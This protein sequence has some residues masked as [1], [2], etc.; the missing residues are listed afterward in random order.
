[1]SESARGRQ[2]F[3]L[4]RDYE[5]LLVDQLWSRWNAVPLDLANRE[6]G[7]VCA[8]LLARQ[9]RLGIEFA[10][11]PSIWNG[12]SAPVLC[13][14][15]VDLLINL[16]W[17]LKDP[18][19]RSRKF[20]LYGLGQA[21]LHLEHR[22]A[23]LHAEGHDP[24]EDPVIQSFEAWID[25][26]RFTFLTEVDVGS[27]SG[28]SVRE[29]ATEAGCLGLLNYSYVPFSAATHSMWHHIGRFNVI[30]C[31]SPLHRHHLLPDIGPEQTELHY[32]DITAKYVERAFEFY[33]SAHGVE[34]PEVTAYDWLLT[35]IDEIGESE[36]EERTVEE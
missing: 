18:V 24:D 19:D 11:S 16:R 20:V 17:V 26:Q 36:Q 27:W 23:Q 5:G 13:R 25:G 33:E 28:L 12:H 15:M 10:R 30:P 29:M 4:L 31:S 21:K 8:A 1:M 2:F 7:E 9:T 34:P 32:L 6:V 35:R 22:K 3:E 14:T